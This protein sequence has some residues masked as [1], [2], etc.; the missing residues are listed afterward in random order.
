VDEE[1]KFIRDYAVTD[2]SVHVS[3]PYL[4]LMPEDPAYPDLDTVCGSFRSGGGLLEKIPAKY[5][6]FRHFTQ[7]QVSK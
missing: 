6:Y 2:A 4:D 7:Y 1:Y 5:R 3:V